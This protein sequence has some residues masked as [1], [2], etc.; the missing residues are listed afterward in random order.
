MKQKKTSPGYMTIGC[1]I[2][3]PDTSIRD[4]LESLCISINSFNWW[5]ISLEFNYVCRFK[6]YSN[7]IDEIFKENS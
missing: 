5:L 4:A 7:K 1:R 2:P 3:I 6:Y